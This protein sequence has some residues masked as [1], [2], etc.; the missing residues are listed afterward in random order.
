MKVLQ[1][2]TNYVNYGG[3]VAVTR[4]DAE[5]LSKVGY[6]VDQL[7]LD[8]KILKRNLLYSF[9]VF[10]NLSRNHITKSK[11]INKL[12][13]FQPDV[14]HIYSYFPQFPLNLLKI[15]KQKNIKIILTINNYRLICSNGYFF[16][17]NSLCFDCL[18]K[19]F[20]SS[21][22]K[23]C[24]KNS[25]LLSYLSTKQISKLW[26]DTILN[27]YVD[28]FFCNHDFAK[29]IHIQYGISSKKILIR[30]NPINTNF[31]YKIEN[32][33]S[34][35]ENFALFVG[36]DSPEKGLDMLINAW[37]SIDYKLIIIGDIKKKNIPNIEF[38]G[39][40]NDQRKKSFFLKAKFLI[41]PSLWHETGVPLVMTESL[42]SC[43]PI[44][45]SDLAPMNTIIKNNYNGFVY[46][47][48]DTEDLKR[49]VITM[50]NKKDTSN[51]SNNAYKTYIDNFSHEKTKNTM[52]EG[53]K[54]LT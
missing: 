27:K 13:K 2:Y 29:K 7:V 44:I 31:S 35:K 52:I 38:R 9:Y 22:K 11:L 12:I 21:T 46:K 36:R 6:E 47:Y 5:I 3:E 24:Y 42:A 26:K 40:L 19:K 41:F 18:N 32:N 54:K 50:I 45:C 25:F 8:N 17:K 23:K 33:T 48:G 1:I 51:L 39:F 10:F 34:N 28:L 16:S 49:K 30:S 14:V 37:K 20:K 53:Y 15:I 4:Y 43:T